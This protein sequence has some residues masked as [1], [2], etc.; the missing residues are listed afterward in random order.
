MRRTKLIYLIKDKLSS[1]F[2]VFAVE[3]PQQAQRIYR[4]TISNVH[5]ADHDDFELIFLAEIDIE[6][7]EVD[8]NGKFRV[9]VLEEDDV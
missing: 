5:P 3:N 7:M 9:T 2:P 6:K 1:D 8:L 4:T